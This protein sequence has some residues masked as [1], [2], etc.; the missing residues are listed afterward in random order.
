MKK[1][2]KTATILTIG[3]ELLIGQTVD[4]NSAWMGAELTKIGIEIVE[5]LTIQDEHQHIIDALDELTSKSDVVLITGGLGPTKDDITKKAIADFLGVEMEFDEGTWTKIQAFFESLGRKTTDAHRI[6]CYMPERATLLPNK[7]GTAPGML[8]HYEDSKII[9]MP[10]VPYEMKYIMSNS[11]IPMLIESA[12]HVIVQATIQ[13]IGRGESLIAE[14]IDPIVDKMP[15]HM[16]IAFLPSLGKVRLRV[17]AKGKDKPSLEE[18][19]HSTVTSMKDI[20]GDIV[21]GEGNINISEALPWWKVN[22]RQKNLILFI[23][24]MTA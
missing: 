24:Y 1:N 8:F 12:G 13:T 9:S 21:F 4:T 14:A 18:E 23:F 11:V 10:G 7:M 22:S 6:Q 15:K 20:L 2:I 19:V 3:D 5:R 16:S 17:T